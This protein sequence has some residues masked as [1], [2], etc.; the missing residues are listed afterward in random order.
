MYDALIVFV[1]IVGG[2][3]SF[4]VLYAAWMYLLAKIIRIPFKQAWRWWR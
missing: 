4:V 3:G 2:F 1:I